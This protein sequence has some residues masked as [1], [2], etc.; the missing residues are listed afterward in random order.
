MSMTAQ[1]E[2]EGGTEKKLTLNQE[3]ALN[4]DTE[5]ASA[6]VGLASILWQVGRE[7]PDAAVDKQVRVAAE[8]AADADLLDGGDHGD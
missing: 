1:Q 5:F 7:H 3:D 6:L 2:A 8:R 4:G